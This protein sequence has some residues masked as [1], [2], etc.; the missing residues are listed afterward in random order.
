VPDYQLTTKFRS[1]ASASFERIALSQF[2]PALGDYTR[3][4][5]QEFSIVKSAPK[6]TQATI[7]SLDEWGKREDAARQQLSAYFADAKAKGCEK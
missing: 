7:S 3:A 2:I 1:F 5:D 6:P 4:L